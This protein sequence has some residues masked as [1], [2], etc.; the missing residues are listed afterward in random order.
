MTQ[1][2]EFVQSDKK[3]K[4]NIAEQEAVERVLNAYLR[5]TQ[6]FDPRIMKPSEQ[7]RT[8]FQNGDPFCI[9]FKETGVTII[10]ELTF[11]SAGGQHAYGSGLYK[12]LESDCMPL[13]S[14]QV[15]SYVLDEIA[16]LEVDESIRRQ[17]QEVLSSHIENSVQ[18][19]EMY[20]KH[21]L[22]KRSDHN[23]NPDYIHSE[24]SLYT[25]H[26]FHPTP[27]SSEGF[28]DQ[29]IEKF[30]PEL[31]VSF[32][33]YYFAISPD[34]ILEEWIEDEVCNHSERC[35]P[36]DV[37][38][39]AKGKLDLEKQGYKLL[40][41]HPWQA[42]R[43]LQN[44]R[45]IEFQEQG[46]IVNLGQ[47]GNAVY[48]TSSVRTV[49]GPKHDYF[50]KLP[51]HVRITNFIRINTR[52]QIKRS[53]DAAT[54]IAKV[55][56]KYENESF[57]ILMEYGY[58]TVS[59]PMS[60]GKDREDVMDAF[61]VLFREN[62]KECKGYDSIYVV[63]S[64]METPPDENKSLLY[65]V[66]KHSHEGEEIKSTIWFSH[67]LK[68]TMTP[69]LKIFAEM[70]VSLEAH[71]QNSL[72][73]IEH[74]LPVKFLVRDLEGI[75]VDGDQ[76][77][78][79][80]WIDSVISKESSVL[81]EKEE[82]WF[83]LKYYYFVNHLG[84]VVRTLAKLSDQDEYHYWRIVR[85]T[86]QEMKQEKISKTLENCINNLLEGEWLPAKANLIS[87]FQDCGE[88]PLFVDIPNPIYDCGVK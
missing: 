17:K 50:Y 52:E 70:G 13:T 56:D 82:A 65:N 33:P 72:V 58:R 41:C 73:K 21:Y 11:W 32:T 9:N 62:P 5:E 1:L 8:L 36:K 15:I 81:Y 69:V 25:G 19:T 22:S 63:G 30:A 31:G 6:V 66:I 28:T 4:I 53:L 38:E 42:Q 79:N 68:V 60:C 35:I 39:E 12:V 85:V 3:Q 16:Y 40:P 26:P 59:L 7:L 61:S 83:R 37:I 54:V 55:R 24:Q 84:Y 51:L 71:A 20:I 86:L 64:L 78:K 80:G 14:Q 67:Y 48:P 88:N 46:K 57:S 87:R 77:L 2:K 43:V 76:A 29:D 45:V 74:G 10:G 34:L 75:S 23:P 27:K 49:W 47:I 44:K 18:K